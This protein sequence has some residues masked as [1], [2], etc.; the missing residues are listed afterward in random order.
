[1]KIKPLK[2]P[3]T[4]YENMAE[5]KRSYIKRKAEEA[6]ADKRLDEYYKHPHDGEEDYAP[7]V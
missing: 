4:E 5:I 7:P 3:R 1:M 2:P 6:E